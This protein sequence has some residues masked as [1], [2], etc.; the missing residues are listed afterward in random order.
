MLRPTRCV[1]LL[2]L[3][4]ALACKGAEG[5]TGPTGPAG[6][7]G[8]QGPVGVTGPTGPVGPQGPIGPPGPVG[9]PGAINRGDLTGVIPASGGASGGLPT[10]AVANG[11][12][13]VIACYISSDQKTWLAVAQTPSVNTVPFCGLTGI[14]SATPAIT[15]VNV[16]P[17][18]FFYMIAVW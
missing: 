14:G 4:I 15:I 12:V 2:L 18:W 17:G 10:A 13:P 9:P 7:Q 16:T 8:P 3:S 5:A 6:P 11:H 1:S